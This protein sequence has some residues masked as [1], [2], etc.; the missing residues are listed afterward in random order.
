MHTKMNFVNYTLSGTQVQSNAV[1]EMHL[2]VFARCSDVL[3]KA[4]VNEKNVLLC[5]FGGILKNI[6]VVT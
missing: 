5:W 4:T 1:A 2:N 3:V 6:Q